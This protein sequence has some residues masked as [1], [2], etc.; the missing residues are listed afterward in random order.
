MTKARLIWLALFAVCAVPVALAISSPLLQWREPIYIAAGL[1]GVLT[2]PLLVMQPL[3]AARVLPD[4]PPRACLLAHRTVALLLLIA[5]C[6]HVAGLWITSPPDVIDALL[7][8]SPT[9]FSLWGVIAMWAGVVTLGLAA[10]WRQFGIAR[11]NWKALHAALAV[12]IAAGAT[13]HALLIDGT[14]EPI[15]KWL[16]CGLVLAATLTAIY[17]R[18]LRGG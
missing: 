12:I 8:V 13:A 5:I 11:Q 15:S 2:L 6:V 14:M 1:A 7:F 17:R 3:F 16:I 18:V 9:P 4:L 10:F